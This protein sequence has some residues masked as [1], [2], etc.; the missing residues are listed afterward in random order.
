MKVPYSKE[1]VDFRLLV[2]VSLRRLR[3]VIY[4]ICIGAI[5]F[6]GT[7]YFVKN[8]LGGRP[9]YKAEAQV[10]LQYIDNVEIENVYINKQTWESLIYNDI[11]AEYAAEEIGRSLELDEVMGKVGATLLTDTRIV[12]VSAQSTSQAEA[13]LLANKYAEAVARFAPEL[14]EID[15]AK[16]IKAATYAEVVGFE[17]RTME[18]SVT[19]AIVGAVI[20]ALLVALYFVWDDS[21]Y[22]PSTSEIRYGIPTLGITTD[23]MRKYSINKQDSYLGDMKRKQNKKT[24]FYRLWLQVNFLKVTRDYKKIAVVDT[25][26]SENYDYVVN[27]LNSV[28]KEKKEEEIFNI[29]RSVIKKEDAYF[30]SPEYDLFAPGSVNRD[31]NIAVCVSKYEAV[32]LLIKSGDHNGK[33]VER[34]LDILRL[35]G[36]NVVGVILYDVNSELIKRYVFSAFSSSTRKLKEEIDNAI[37]ASDIGSES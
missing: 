4:G 32:I 7:Y 14:K 29:D 1:P 10:Y 27:L 20:A 15:A 16:V 11:I 31:P 22:I 35:Q 17:D 26:L 9:E 13:R 23:S 34:A 2:L 21:I 3:F 19:G 18:M 30:S 12:V 36:A 33:Q 5:V 25:S 24:E 37:N 28:V 6:G 8:V